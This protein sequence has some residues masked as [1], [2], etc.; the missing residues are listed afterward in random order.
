[1]TKPFSLPYKNEMVERMTGSTPESARKVARET[2]IAQ[3]TLSGW[4]REARNLPLVPTPKRTSQ[5]TWTIDERVRVL[6]AASKLS[7]VELTTLLAREGLLLAELEQWRLALG[8]DTKATTAATKR[9]R[10]LE[11]EL[12]RKENALAADDDTDEEN[13]S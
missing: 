1:M 4:L 11:K 12:A 7:G 10:S 8:E 6:S 9:I 5:K 2:G 3:V 13:D